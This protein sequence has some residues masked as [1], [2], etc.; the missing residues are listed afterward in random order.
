MVPK[1]FSNTNT[2]YW[3]GDVVVA[4]NQQYYIISKFFTSGGQIFVETHPLIHHNLDNQ[5]LAVLGIET[6]CIPLADVSFGQTITELIS[7]YGIVSGYV[8]SNQQ[9]HMSVLARHHHDMI[10]SAT[11][12]RSRVP[13]NEETG[14]NMKVRIV[15][16]SLF[17]DDTTGNTSKKWNCYD[18][19]TMNVAAFPLVESNKYENHFVLCTSN[20]KITAMD[21]AAPLVE[22]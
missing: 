19:W 15:P 20:H 5:R 6:V 13:V 4:P 3:V 21:M 17:S 1:E 7:D 8:D 22:V 14:K 18:S 10:H 11:N 16:I 2:D 9:L 12:Y